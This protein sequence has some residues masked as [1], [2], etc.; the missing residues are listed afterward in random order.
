MAA[1][2]NSSLKTSLVG[3]GD[4]EVVV[5]GPPV[6]DVVRSGS[7]VEVGRGPAADSAETRAGQLAPVVGGSEVELLAADDVVL[8]V[9]DVL[10][11]T[12]VSDGERVA[13]R[14]ASLSL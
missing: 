1:S 8:V 6:V 4:G 11:C 13:N 10:E 14:A 5:R 2:E 9:L 3:L 12:V 7:V